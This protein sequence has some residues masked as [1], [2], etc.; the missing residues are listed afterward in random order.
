V[1]VTVPV[2]PA[3][4]VTGGDVY[5]EMSA[6]ESVTVPVRPA[7][8]KTGGAVYPLTSA[9]VSVTAPVLP[10]TE[11]TAP[12]ALRVPL[13]VT[14]R[15]V[16]TMIPPMVVVVAG[17]SD[18]GSPCGPVGPCGPVPPLTVAVV[19]LSVTDTLTLVSLTETV[20]GL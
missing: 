12:V 14:L 15:P 1:S 16:P 6:V 5:P 18:A 8:D 3:T 11:L 20:T 4:L 19:T 7:T 13:P 10:A 9:V 2:R 17:V